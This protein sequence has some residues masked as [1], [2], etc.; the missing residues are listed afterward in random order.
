VYIIR[1]IRKAE[2]MLGE[3]N[4]KS[5]SSRLKNRTHASAQK[6]ILCIFNSKLSGG[7]EN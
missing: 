2:L 7:L 5:L 4:D 1:I 3:V 6:L